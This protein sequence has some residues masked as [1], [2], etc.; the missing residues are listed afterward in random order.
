MIGRRLRAIV[1]FWADFVVGD[2]PTVAI[3]VVVAATLTA[4]LVHSGVPAWWVLPAATAVLLAVSL[5]RAG[6]AV[7]TR[8][9]G[10]ASA[11]DHPDRR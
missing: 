8:G 5:L 3:G 9:R 10:A 4:V 11:A 7:R 6:R 2:D 1:A